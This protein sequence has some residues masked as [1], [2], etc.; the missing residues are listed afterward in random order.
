MKLHP[1][2]PRQPVLLANV[3]QAVA[4]I[5]VTC[6]LFAAMMTV[7]PPI[8]W[9]GH[10]D[11]ARGTNMAFLFGLVRDYVAHSFNR[12][13]LL[14]AM[15]QLIDLPFALASA[16]STFGVGLPVGVRGTAALLVGAIAGLEARQ[17]VLADVLAEPLVSHVNGPQ[18]VAGKAA[19]RSLSA[20]WA[21]RFGG[22][23]SG[24]EL[25]AGL[26][27]PRPLEAEHI[28]LAGGTGAGKTTVMETIMDSAIK[29][30]DKIL[31]LDV[32]GDVTARFP[33]D[34]F[35]L[36]ALDDARSSRW[37]LGLDIV[38]PEDAAE[39][40]TEIIR[41]TN[42]PSWS[43][44][45]R[46]VLT[47]IL[48][49]LQNEAAKRGKVWSWTDLD[50]ILSKPVADLFRLLRQSDP[51]AASLINVEQDQTQRQAMSFYFVLAANAGQMAKAFAAMGGS[52]RNVTKSPG[53]SIRRWARGAGSANLILR[54]SRRQ[55]ELSASMF[56]IV[57]KIVADNA[58]SISYSD[59][60]SPPATWL[61]LDELPQLGHSP[62]IPRLAAIGR[63]LGVRIVAAIQSPAQLKEIYGADGAQ[64]LLDNMTTKIVGRLA[65]GS[66]AS[67]ISSIWIGNRTVSWM[68]ETGHG[69]DGKPRSE[70]KTQGIPV[71]D[72]Q[73]LSDALGLTARSA[74]SSRI[75]ALVIGHGNIAML[76]WPVG[77]W[78]ARRPADVP[79]QGHGRS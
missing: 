36:L 1:L 9:L 48:V 65:S 39:L 31:A 32:K 18:L 15:I 55:P 68:E 30:G 11:E 64:H 67:E 60:K 2:T 53:V 52:S 49:R 51:V 76:S 42:D 75:R 19:I 70:R 14:G 45:A 6:A 13:D 43:A 24:V 72:P 17:A 34:D 59:G 22:A 40:A 23:D 21:K 66:T 3:S 74:K 16:L 12:N 46:Q 54:Q 57:L 50:Q 4:T 78:N 44:G 28:L 58:G 29:R 35:C 5:V 33:I 79:R 37:M 56:R 8:A 25:V 10:L 71:V 61:C 7:L 41:E 63:S 20:A 38:T 77:L 62:A 69:P 47:A 73:F 27:M 26:T